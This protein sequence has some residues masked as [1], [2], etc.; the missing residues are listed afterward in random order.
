LVPGRSNDNIILGGPDRYYD[1]GA[2]T[3]PALGFL[4]NLGRNTLRGPGF[5]N[6]DF[7]L[8]KDTSL[9]FLGESGKLEFRAEF[10][11]ILNRVN[12]GMPNRTVLAARAD[13]ENPLANAGRITNTSGSSRQIQIALKILF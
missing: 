10:F 3:V 12:F 2:F 1:P 8:V 4:G 7:S 11:N 13:V 5:A 6:L 9:R